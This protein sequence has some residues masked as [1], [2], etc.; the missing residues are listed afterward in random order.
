MKRIGLLSDHWGHSLTLD[1][2]NQLSQKIDFRLETIDDFRVVESLNQAIWG[3]INLVDIVVAHIERGHPSIYYAIGLAHGQGKPVIVVADQEVSIPVQLSGQRY[4]RINNQT[5]TKESLAFRL[6]EAVFD[7]E[8]RDKPYSGPRS[9][10]ELHQSYKRS[11]FDPSSIAEFRS[12]YTYEGA[13]RGL[14]FE[15]WFAALARAVPGWEVLESSRSRGPDQGF[16]L[17]IWNSREDTD[18]AVLGNPIAVEL[19]AIRSMNTLSLSHFL[20]LAK[21]GGLKG[22]VLATTGINDTRT[23][24]LLSRLRRDQGICAIALDRDDL[25]QIRAPQDLLN[26]FKQK[27]RELLVEGDL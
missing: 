18:L 10:V 22:L 14:R 20:H 25:I 17:V 2:L 1:A 5:E 16:N 7:A 21:I 3:L 9:N 6:K 19:K 27:V 23:K 24:R 8:Q 15:Q 12:L 13:A 4:I 11:S 26:L